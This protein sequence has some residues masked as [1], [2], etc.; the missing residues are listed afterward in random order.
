MTEQAGAIL[1]LVCTLVCGV[2]AVFGAEMDADVLFEGV[3]C[4]LALACLVWTWWKNNNMTD[5]AVAA[6][7][8]LDTLKE[9]G[10]YMLVQ[11]GEGVEDWDETEEDE[12]EDEETDEE[13][14]IALPDA[15]WTKAE[16]I[17]WCS[18]Q[19]V[20]VYESWN[21]TKLLNAVEA[22]VKELE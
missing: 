8:V 1:R 9:G 4:A 14:E 18:E 12:T 3:A 10:S 15:S 13:D 22:Y 5:A 2:A 6:Q 17:E 21:K 19:G 11:D 20:E 16:I 7:Q